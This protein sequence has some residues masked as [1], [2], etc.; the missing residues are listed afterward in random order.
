MRSLK[1][2]EIKKR[3]RALLPVA[4]VCENSLKIEDYD[5]WP[6]NARRYFNMIN[7]VYYRR[8]AKILDISKADLGA[9]IRARNHKK[10][11][12]FKPYT[13]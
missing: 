13:R 1:S 11:V 7:I 2:K 9:F 3:Y 6:I 10:Q 4:G 5:H 8:I 12:S